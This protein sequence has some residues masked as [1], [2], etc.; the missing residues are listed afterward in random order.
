VFNSI[1]F[2]GNSSP[3]GNGGSSYGTTSWSWTAWRKSELTHL[4]RSIIT[5]FI[6]MTISPN[7]LRGEAVLKTAG[8][9]QAGLGPDPCATERRLYSII[10]CALI[11][12]SQQ[13]HHLLTLIYNL[14]F[15]LFVVY[16]YIMLIC[17][18]MSLPW[19]RMCKSHRKKSINLISPRN[20]YNIN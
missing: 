11:P 9:G 20:H 4:Y 19:Y 14:A 10:Y 15:G 13:M 17:H 8:T 5:M 18:F 6:W 12:C 1:H 7:P 16:I 2:H 3:G